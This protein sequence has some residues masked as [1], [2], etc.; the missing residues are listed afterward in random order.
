[1]RNASRV[2]EAALAE[3]PLTSS[4]YRKK[5]RAIIIPWCF[6]L[7]LICL[8]GLSISLSSAA[9]THFDFRTQYT[10][11]YMARTGLRYAGSP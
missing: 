11:G 2:S 7:L 4:L 5:V 1:M 10:A 9:R 3:R 8:S 6:F